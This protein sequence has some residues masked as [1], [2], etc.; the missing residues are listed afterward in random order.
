MRKGAR[1][2]KT[3]EVNG[4]L[5]V[6]RVASHVFLAGHAATLTQT[7]QLL[8]RPDTKTETILWYSCLCLSCSPAV[9]A[10]R[11]LGL[12]SMMSPTL[13]ASR[14]QLRT[15]KCETSK[16]TVWFRSQ[17]ACRIKVNRK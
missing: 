7:H 15:C 9:L 17:A 11:V 3:D 6:T 4:C 12:F 10:G 16:G 2:V 14:S 13:P 5:L 8:N 1:H